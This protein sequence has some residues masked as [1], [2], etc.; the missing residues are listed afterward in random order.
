MCGSGKN[1]RVSVLLRRFVLRLRQLCPSL[2]SFSNLRWN[3]RHRQLTISWAV[4][5]FCDSV[6]CSLLTPPRKGPPSWSRISSAPHRWQFLFFILCTTL[7]ILSIS[8]ITG[9]IQDM[10][11][12]GLTF[13]STMFSELVC[14]AAC[15]R[16]LLFLIAES[17]GWI[18]LS[19]IYPLTPRHVDHCHLLAT[20]NMLLWTCV[21]RWFECL[22]RF[23]GFT[24]GSKVRLLALPHQHS[25]RKA[26]SILIL[27]WR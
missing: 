7:S 27:S 12:L 20:V 9:I 18:D 24:A 16:T 10:R 5:T 8:F 2:H 15:S 3:S 25:G 17:Y 1:I 22:F 14:V 23:F 4:S 19:F 21:Y 11:T 6:L 13:I 26:H